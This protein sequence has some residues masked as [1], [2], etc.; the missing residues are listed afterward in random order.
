MLHP[1]TSPQVKSHLTQESD[2]ASV[3]DENE[4]HFKVGSSNIH[5]HHGEIVQGVFENREGGLSRGLLTLPCPLY[6][7]QA[8]FHPDRIGIVKVES[9]DGFYKQKA[10][11]AA[12]LTLEKIGKQGRGGR[13]LIRS[14]IPLSRGCGSSTADVIATLKAVADAFGKSLN[15]EEVAC[16]AVK[17]EKAAD[18]I[19]FGN[20]AVLFAQREGFVIEDLGGSL[21]P[22]EVV[23]FNTDESGIDTLSF[24]PARYNFWEIEKFRVLRGAVR[25]AIIYQDPRLIGRVASAS[26]CINQRF[27]PKPKFDQFLE[28]VEQVGALGLQIAHSGTVVGLLFDPNERRNEQ[29]I[30]SAQSL[31]TEIG[32]AQTLRFTTTS[33]NT[34]VMA[35]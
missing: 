2:R 1:F 4:V 32:F 10:Q 16:L 27:L 13:L 11:Q 22:L 35:V 23:G 28:I 3:S 9:E 29:K 20:R 15:P 26:A 8:S 24:P 30:R 31:L 6:W 17:A 25:R 19:M 33:S 5:A 14:N 7:T 34:E 18:S 21:P 12:Q